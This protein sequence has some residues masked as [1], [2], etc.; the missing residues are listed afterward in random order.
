V[1]RH[2]GLD[3][4]GQDTEEMERQRPKKPSQGGRRP[5]NPELVNRSRANSLERMA[6]ASLKDEK[7]EAEDEED[8][9][10]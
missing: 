3:G 7:T 2:E 9:D 10:Q 8:E 6:H 4:G 5:M 1:T